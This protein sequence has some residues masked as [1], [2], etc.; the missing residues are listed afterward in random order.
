MDSEIA[1][2]LVSQVFFVSFV[3]T[4]VWVNDVYDFADYVLQVGRFGFEVV[5]FCVFELFAKFRE[6]VLGFAFEVVV[7]VRSSARLQT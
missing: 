2:C 7:M 5:E 1:L 3:V 4:V 6:G